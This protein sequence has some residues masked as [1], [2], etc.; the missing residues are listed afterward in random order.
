LSDN[1]SPTKRYGGCQCGAARYVVYGEPE[2]VVVCHCTTCQKQSGSAFAVVV[3]VDKDA[4]RLTCGEVRQFASTAESGR[5]RKG[6][7]C[8]KCGSRLYHE[9]EW[10][11]GKVSIRGG[12]FDDTGWLRP[13]VH[14]WTKRKQPWVI[15]PDDVTKFETQSDLEPR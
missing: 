4:F 5:A 3:V 13:Q 7:F 15:I 6:V 12:T 10:R 11:P 9:I 1:A 2:Q 14:L 8:T